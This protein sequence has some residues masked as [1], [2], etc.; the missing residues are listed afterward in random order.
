MPL[1][2]HQCAADGCPRM[3]DNDKLMCPGH[4]F[5][6]PDEIRRRVWS[7]WRNV[8]RDRQAYQDARDEAVQHIRDHVPATKVNSPKRQGSLF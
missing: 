7:T 5:A 2:Q 1:P 4:W 3:V 6:V 8:H